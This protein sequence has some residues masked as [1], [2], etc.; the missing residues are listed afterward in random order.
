MHITN[1]WKPHI[2]TKH[3]LQDHLHTCLLTRHKTHQNHKSHPK[4]HPYLKLNSH[5][6]HKLYPKNKVASAYRRRHSTNN[7]KHIQNKHS[8][9]KPHPILKHHPQPNYQLNFNPHAKYKH[10]P[11]NSTGSAYRPRHT[12]KNT[13]HLI[14]NWKPNSITNQIPINNSILHSSPKQAENTIPTI[15]NLFTTTKP[16][17]VIYLKTN[18]KK[19]KVLHFNGYYFINKLE[20]LKCGDIELNPGP[21]PNILH[22]HPATHK[23]EPR[24]NL[25]Q[26]L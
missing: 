14:T 11:K 22:T 7:K 6:K 13:Y 19:S 23:K 5:T 17:I 1:K 9:H 24:Y 8:K 15:P 20:L 4:N 12:N 21:M 18:K 3:I 26:T 16:T 10:N 25:F 2:I